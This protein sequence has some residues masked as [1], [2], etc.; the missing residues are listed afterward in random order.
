VVNNFIVLIEGF[1]THNGSITDLLAEVLLKSGYEEMLRLGGEEDRLDNLAELKRSIY[2]FEITAGEN[3]SLTDYL[4]SVALLTNADLPEDNNKVKL[5]TIHTA[6]GLEAPFVF[7]VGLNEGIFPSRRAKNREKLEEERRLA[8]VAFTR[9]KK[10]LFLT[11]SEGINP[12]GGFRYPSRFIF[13]AEKVNLDY[14]V[15][16]PDDLIEK[17]NNVVAR[18]EMR[19]SSPR[20][21]VGEQVVHNVFGVGKIVSIDVRGFSYSVKFANMTTEREISFETSDKVLDLYFRK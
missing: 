10:M 11:E 8:Y 16:L 18:Q 12:D 2:E 5:M 13:N 6:K 9:A 3:V 1:S 17:A 20:Y 14:V 15:E 4:D 7:V 19:I 21:R